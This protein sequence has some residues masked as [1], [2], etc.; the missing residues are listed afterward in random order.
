MA[1]SSPRAIPASKFR[2]WVE[3]QGTKDGV[4]TVFT[5]PDVFR[6]TSTIRIKIYVNGV[7]QDVDCD[8][9][10]SGGSGPETGNTITFLFTP[11]PS[12]KLFADYIA[13]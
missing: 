8:Y 9:V 3:L 12:D 7:R 1:V 5:T 6:E 13:V 2:D 11:K 10:V 4:N